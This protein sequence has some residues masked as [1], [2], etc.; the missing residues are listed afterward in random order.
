M[1]TPFNSKARAVRNAE[2]M[3]RQRSEWDLDS[4]CAK[5]AGQAR[6][7]Q[8]HT[9]GNALPCGRD[10]GTCRS[11]SGCSGAFGTSSSTIT[12]LPPTFAVKWPAGSPLR[13]PV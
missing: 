4:D 7:R 13:V 2:K 11:I 9:K 6:E 8:C 1:S 10:Q 12:H 5:P 3:L